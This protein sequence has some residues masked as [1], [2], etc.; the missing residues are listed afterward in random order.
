MKKLSLLFLLLLTAALVIS[1]TE[2]PVFNPADLTAE[3]IQNCDNFRNKKG[4]VRWDEF[5]KNKH[6]FP[7][8]K[9]DADSTSKVFTWDE[10]TTTF[11]MTRKQL[12]DLIGAPDFED[13]AYELGLERFDCEVYFMIDEDDNVLGHAYANCTGEDYE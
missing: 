5:Q 10:N 13:G 3:E 8:S 4:Q 9:I 11:I 1:Q 7:E 6:L 12:I 2:K